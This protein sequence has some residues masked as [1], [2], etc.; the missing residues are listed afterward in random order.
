[1]PSWWH[2]SVTFLHSIGLTVF[3]IIVALIPNFR[4]M[5]KIDYGWLDPAAACCFHERQWDLHFSLYQ[6]LHIHQV[7]SSLQTCTAAYILAF[8]VELKSDMFYKIICK[9]ILLYRTYYVKDGYRHI[10]PFHSRIYAYSVLPNKRAY[11]RSCSREKIP[12]R[13]NLLGTMHGLCTVCFNAKRR[14]KFS[15]NFKIQKIIFTK[16]IDNPPVIIVIYVCIVII[17]RCW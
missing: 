15:K 7:V 3:G 12:L 11:A 1:M 2:T 6:K 10:W 17:P 9:R 14:S 4:D 8:R 13:T 16:N 5:Q